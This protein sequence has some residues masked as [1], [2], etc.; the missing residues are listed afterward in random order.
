MSTLV[1]VVLR[2]LAD[3]GIQAGADPD[4]VQRSLEFIAARTKKEGEEFLTISLPSFA[5]DFERSLADGQ[6]TAARFQR[7]KKDAA[8]RPRF[9]GFFMS[10]LF[11]EQGRLRDDVDP[12]VVAFVRQI[13]LM[14]KKTHGTA[15][16]ERRTAA[17]GSYTDVERDIDLAWSN[18]DFRKV[19]RV[20]MSSI[21]ARDPEGFNASD[22]RP[23]HGPG[24]TAEG[25]TPN[26]KW[27]FSIWHDR[28]E[29]VFPYSHHC[30]LNENFVEE[31]TKEGRV[32]F[33]DERDEQPV[34]VVFVPKT[35][36]TPRVIA[37]EPS[38]MQYIQQG[39]MD[40]LVP[41]IE[42]G[43]YTKGRVNFTDQTKNQGLALLSSANESFATLDMKE[44]SDRVSYAHA[45]H[46]FSVSPALWAV[47]EACR[48]RSAKLP[49]GQ[50]VVL[51]K[52]A[53]MGS[54]LC[55]PVE[56]MVFFCTIV[57]YRL[58]F[59]AMPITPDNIFQMS[60]DVYVYGDDIVVPVDEAPAICDYLEA[61]G[62]RVNRDKSF[63]SGKFRESCGMDAYDGQDVTPVYCRYPV[64]NDRKDAKALTSYVALANGLHS[65]GLW[66]SA[67]FVRVLVED[68][69]GKI[70]ASA[71]EG[72]GLRWST[73]SKLTDVS[74][75]N[76]RLHCFEV[77]TWV[78][79]TV[80]RKD[81]L[82]GHAALMKCFASLEGK[83]RALRRTR[84]C[85]EDY[86]RITGALMRH[87]STTPESSGVPSSDVPHME[88][89]GGVRKSLFAQEILNDPEYYMATQRRMMEESLSL[90][91][92]PVISEQEHLL[93][94]SRRHVLKLKH[95][96]VRVA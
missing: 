14:C 27:T 11:D 36:K 53:S 21:L 25:F 77:K 12:D 69:L 71:V 47:V 26:G 28:L 73:F 62:L 91:L 54:A 76:S 38:C 75:W 50:T 31:M 78:P 86:Y 41:L 8:G 45:K 9:L 29:K 59:H 20:I 83:I 70:P 15:S 79:V 52:F 74:R 90:W 5:S 22:I 92:D 48:S 93:R 19:A 33:R 10:R 6:L 40:Y 2:V 94:S 3:A 42:S 51:K 23:K 49:D 39:L 55:F 18:D 24:A 61:Q 80:E 68:I 85:L 13:T 96:W 4:E 65:R 7:W 1:D 34:K 84:E 81:R 72:E 44:A 95:A 16:E 32:D 56:A 60:R 30:L 67:A 46:L 88:C 57:T 89:Y 63:W 17:L 87:A 37:I 64:P 35:V 58:A 43:F 82:D 66:Q